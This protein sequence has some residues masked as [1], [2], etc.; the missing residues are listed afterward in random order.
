MIQSDA[1]PKRPYQRVA[2]SLREQ[3]EAGHWAAGEM[4]PG[5]QQLARQQGVALGTLERAIAALI[6]EGLLR[7]E[8][9]R[10]TFVVAAPP[11]T[12]PANAKFQ[13]AASRDGEPLVATIGIAAT[14]APYSGG[15]DYE[16][17]W[18]IQVLHG[19]EHRLASD[20]GLTMRF[21]NTVRPGQPDLPVAEAV[22]RL[23]DEGVDAVIAIGLAVP[24]GFAAQFASTR[25]PLVFAAYDR[26][27]HPFPQVYVD[28]IAAGAMAA[29][30]LLERGYRHLLYFQPFTAGWTTERL[31][32]VQAVLGN[33]EGESALRVLPAAPTGLPSHSHEQ[34]T[35][36]RQCAPSVLDAVREGGTGVIATNDAVAEGFMEAARERG[37]EAGRDYGLVGFDD[38]ARDHG[39]TS[40]R[41]PLSELGGEAAGLALRLLRGASAPTR[42][43]LQHRLMARSSTAPARMEVERA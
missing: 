25:I 3:I 4:L 2:D 22:T 8:D 29:R 9:R 30:H 27:E 11:I 16:S 1:L 28:D 34:R 13:S 7:V 10:G 38:R 26:A 43:A 39:V 41:P 35:I 36:A 23:L 6:F 18:P 14:V 31:V 24:P 12:S 20:T 33:A 37:L 21:L 42:I 19:C 40:L 15:E 17:Q 32:G 5:R